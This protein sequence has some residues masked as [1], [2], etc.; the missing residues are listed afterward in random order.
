MQQELRIKK[1]IFPNKERKI[2]T[3]MDL[4]R[5]CGFSIIFYFTYM[6]H[7]DNMILKIYESYTNKMKYETE[8]Q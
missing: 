7:V 4:E 8:T 5:K 6:H 2:K 1:V 3:K